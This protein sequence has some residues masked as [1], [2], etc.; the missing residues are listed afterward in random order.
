[1]A[2]LLSTPAELKTHLSQLYDYNK[3]GIYCHF[4]AIDHLC[5]LEEQR[6]RF[7]IMKLNQHPLIKIYQYSPSLSSLIGVIQGQIKALGDCS[8]SRVC[9]ACGFLPFDAIS[10][11]EY[12]SEEDVEHEVPPLYLLY[13]TESDN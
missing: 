9:P 8:N 4:V 13:G 7:D 1:M 11:D 6:A 2:V 3:F 12:N 5:E 10:S